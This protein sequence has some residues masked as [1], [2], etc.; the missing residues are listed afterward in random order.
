MNT[1]LDYRGLALAH[2]AEGRSDGAKENL[3]LLHGWGSDSRIWRD[4][5]PFLNERYKVYCLDLPGFGA[6]AGHQLW[7]DDERLLGALAETLPA[8]SHLV[9]WSLGGNVALAFADRFPARV[10]SLNLVACNLSFVAREGWPWGMS[11]EDFDAF[12]DL[13]NTSVAKALR[14]FQQLQVQGDP[15]AR[16]LVRKLRALAGDAFDYDEAS[17]VAALGWLQRQDQ[18]ELAARIKLPVQHV[19][20]EIDCLV[21][22]AV[23]AKLDRATVLE[24]SGHIPMLSQPRLL[25]QGIMAT[26]EAELDKRRVARSFS[27]AAASY[28]AAAK[29]QRAVGDKLVAQL[30]VEGEGIG[31]D[32]GCGTG[33]FLRGPARRSSLDW[34]GGDLAEGMLRH[35]ADSGAH[36]S[37]HLLGL[38]AESLPLQTGSIQAVY[39][40]LALQWCVDLEALFAELARVVGPGGWL[41]FS[42]LVDGTLAELKN[43]WRQVDGHVHVNRFL[44]AGCWYE[45]ALANGWQIS[46]WQVEN[47][48]RS[49]RDLKELLHELKALG[50]H[51]V[52]AGMPTG[53]TGKSSW[54]QLRSAYED[55]RQPDDSLPASWKVLYG[56]LQRG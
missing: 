55:F 2:S 33:Y 25:A 45:A 11:P 10:R 42:T 19:L 24:G 52:N 41:G 23:A 28:D 32:L 35:A 8:R 14:R 20:G 38:D 1:A 44:D 50:A 22:A 18:R 4:V 29:M 5:V 34:V 15:A 37:S 46:H 13:A 43:A 9:G 30:P 40:N 16:E 7:N 49:Y 56:V 53:L 3:V 48:V 39:S 51:N 54:R 6:N 31:L 36:P 47:R 21:P 12:Y 17:L 27:R 26:G